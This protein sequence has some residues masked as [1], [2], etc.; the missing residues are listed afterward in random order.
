MERGIYDRIRKALRA[1]GCRRK[2]GRFTYTDT[3]VLA[4][5]LWATVNDR[6]VRWACE[7]QNWPRGLRRGP[8]PD[9][10]TVSRRMRRA[11]MATLIDRLREWILPREGDGLV[12]LIDGKPLTV[13]PNSHDRQ[14][15][16]GRAASGMAKGYK[17]HAIVDAHGRVMAWRVAPMNV[18]ERAM[19]GRMLRDLEHTGYLVGDSNYDSRKLYDLA[20]ER[21]IQLVAPRARHRRHK[22]LGHRRTSEH[23][24]R[25]IEMLERPHNG[26]GKAL[27]SFRGAIERYFGQLTYAGLGSLP[28]WV[29][30]YRRVRNWVAA[31]LLIHATKT[32]IRLQI[33]Q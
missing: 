31:K 25:S 22:G 9:A 1:V 11:S 24:I 21:G 28:A 15:G 29:R 32:R 27:L 20:A 3:G 26:F 19:A 30:G 14:A 13:G 5:Y 23:R 6:P 16:Y 17:L 18:D 10:S 33:V 8:L 2:S 4:V 7:P 12:A